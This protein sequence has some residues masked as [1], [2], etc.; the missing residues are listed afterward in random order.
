MRIARPNPAG[1]QTH[2]TR[3][4]VDTLIAALPAA[5]VAAGVPAPVEEREVSLQAPQLGIEGEAA[6]SSARID[7]FGRPRNS[8]ETPSYFRSCDVAV[9]GTANVPI[10]TLSNFRAVTVAGGTPQWCGVLTPGSADDQD[11]G[12]WAWSA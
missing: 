12:S 1:F 7:L 5:I 3:G 9:T 10:V 4:C 11:L 8:N 6:L 2:V